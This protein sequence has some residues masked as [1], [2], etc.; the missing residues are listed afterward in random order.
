[1]LQV[2]WVIWGNFM[3][4]RLLS[5]IVSLSYLYYWLL[6]GITFLIQYQSLIVPALSLLGASPSCHE[7]VQV[8]Q[9]FPAQGTQPSLGTLDA[10]FSVLGDHSTLPDLVAT[11]LSAVCGSMCKGPIGLARVSNHCLCIGANTK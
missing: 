10:P 8:A 7:D 3:I 5:C 9:V 4:A 2:H 1:M 6:V 11:F